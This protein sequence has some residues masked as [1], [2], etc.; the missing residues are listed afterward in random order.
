MRKPQIEPLFWRQEGESSR[1]PPTYYIADVTDMNFES[2]FLASIYVLRNCQ[3]NGI[4]E[5]TLENS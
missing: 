2:Q 4:M 5:Y 3:Q 1:S